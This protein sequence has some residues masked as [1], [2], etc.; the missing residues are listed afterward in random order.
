VNTKN[1]KGAGRKPAP[2]PLLR[3]SI[4]FSTDEW[5]QIKTLANQEGMTVSEYIRNKSLGGNRNDY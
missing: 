3:K 1:P 4:R 2:N 5:N